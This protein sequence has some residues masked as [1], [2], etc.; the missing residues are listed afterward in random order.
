MAWNFAVWPVP[1]AYSGRSANSAIFWST[2]SLNDASASAIAAFR[3]IMAEAQ[4][5]LDPGARNSKRLPVK[6]KGDVRLRSVLSMMRSGIC[7]MSI[8]MFFL[9]LTSNRSPPS[10]LSSSSVS[11]VPR[12]LEIIAGGASLPP[13][14]WAFVAL[15][16]LAFSSPLCLYT[17][18]SVSTMNV[19]KRN[20][21]L[22]A[23]SAVRPSVLPGAC[24]N[25]PVSVDRLQLLC[26]PLPLMPSKGFSCS[27]TRKP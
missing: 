6:A 8:C 10:I 14:R 9:P 13:K 5:T 18:I 20:V 7:G 15:M 1:S 2:R 25:T 24:S 19:T 17:A 22:V 27:S 12:K 23:A 21:S 16:M 3:A 26:L 4:L 11:C